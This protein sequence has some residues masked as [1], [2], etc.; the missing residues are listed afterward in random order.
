MKM[1]V[2]KMVSESYEFSAASAGTGA[3][4]P[5]LT[6]YRVWLSDLKERQIEKAEGQTDFI[7]VGEKQVSRVNIIASVV[8]KYLAENYGSL[9]LDDGSAQLR[10]KAFGDFLSRIKDIESGDIILTIAR[11]REY[12]NEIYMFPEIV[13]KVTA[14]H[15]LLRRLELIL[16][17]GRRDPG[18]RGAGR[19]WQG[20]QGTEHGARSEEQ[21]W[22]FNP[23][24]GERIQKGPQGNSQGK[25]GSADAQVQAQQENS[26]LPS[27]ELKERVKLQ[28]AKLDEGEGV[29][30]ALI[31]QKIGGNSKEAI[32]E[33]I[34]ELLGEGEA[35]EPRPGE[36]KLI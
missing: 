7:S 30:L 28:I 31:E 32:S 5:R 33:I 23:K 13:K 14:K 11:I 35:Y 4:R 27:A 8:D 10:L 12:N 21:N 1:G 19:A 2:K 6:A 17:N 9:T 16:E 15:A 18:E 29:E 26:F 36:V 34:E 20:A 3:S 24:T 22:E 25:N